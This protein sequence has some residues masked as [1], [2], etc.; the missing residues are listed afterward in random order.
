MVGHRILILEHPVKLTV[1][2]EAGLFFEIEMINTV[3]RHGYEIKVRDLT[4][5]DPDHLDRITYSADF[6]LVP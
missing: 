2:Q 4:G 5:Y 1:E 6:Q 3:Q